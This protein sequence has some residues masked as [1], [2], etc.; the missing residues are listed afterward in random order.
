MGSTRSNT[1]YKEVISVFNFDGETALTGL[2]ASD[3]SFT[4]LQNG[5]SYTD[6][7]T[8]AVTELT[9]GRYDV[10]MTFPSVGFWTI[11][12]DISVISV[13]LET[14]QLNVNVSDVSGD[15]IYL[16]SVS[17]GSTVQTTVG[18]IDSGTTVESLSDG[19]KTIADILDEILFPPPPRLNPSI[20]QPSVSLASS[21]TGLQRAGATVNITFTTSAS[22]GSISAS[23]INPTEDYAGALS[24]AE[25]AHDGSSPTLSVTGDT[26]IEDFQASSY[27]VQVGNSNSWTLRGT[28]S[29]G[30]NIPV[31]SYGDASGAAFAGGTK[32]SS[33]SFEGVYPVFIKNSSNTFDEMSLRSHSTSTISMSQPFNETVTTRHAIKIPNAMGTSPT[34]QQWNSIS[35]SYSTLAADQ[36]TSSAITET[37]EGNTIN[38]TLYEK[39]GPIG[40][41]DVGAQALYQV[42]GL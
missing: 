7:I 30:D 17:G 1:T 27:V 8:T 22:L 29:S 23:W 15:S 12:I 34:F 4:F 25:Y 37:I 39:A 35:E 42:T 32:S 2:T 36:F 10:E 33:I 18:G 14:Y 26:G 20:S 11:F 40:G 21:I 24:G 31:D 9:D 38:Y 3:F 13:E 28:F 16:S 19:S 6:S 41:G 5:A